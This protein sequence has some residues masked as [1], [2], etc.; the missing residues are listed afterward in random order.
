[1]IKKIDCVNG[2]HRS[3]N[4][5][6]DNNRLVGYDYESQCCEEFGY[7]YCKFDFD[8]EVECIENCCGGS[9]DVFDEVDTIGDPDLSNAHFAAEQPFA[10]EGKYKIEGCDDCN[11]L[12]L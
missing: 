6:D 3:V 11:W 8:A 1:M 10:D 12:V 5:V 2:W 4:W 9:S 7:E